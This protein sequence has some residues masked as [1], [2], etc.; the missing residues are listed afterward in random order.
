MAASD[1]SDVPVH[2]VVGGSGGIGSVLCRRLAETGARLVIAGR[3]ETSVGEL[4]DELDAGRAIVDGTDI[5][6]VTDLVGQVK[7]DEG[8]LDG[9]SREA[10]LEASR[11]MHAVGRIGTPEDVAS[12]IAWLLDPQNTWVTGQVFGVDGGISRVRAR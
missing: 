8:R 4:A 1:T 5:E 3:N 2:L 9:A 6:A 11:E 7:K 10:A 12:M